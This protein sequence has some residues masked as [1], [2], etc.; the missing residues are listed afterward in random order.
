MKAAL[1]FVIPNGTS[2]TKPLLDGIRF[3]RYLQL[4]SDH[5]KDEWMPVWKY[6]APWMSKANTASACL[7]CQEIRDLLNRRCTVAD[8]G[9]IIGIF[10]VHNLPA[11]SS[12]L[13]STRP[14]KTSCRAS[15]TQS[16]KKRGKSRRTPLYAEKDGEN[17]SWTSILSGKVKLFGGGQVLHQQGVT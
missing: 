9:D 1:A 8:Q 10:W 12:I 7:D 16:W 5:Q 2:F 17:C 14:D 15:L 11:S 3:A 6:R 13:G 4:S